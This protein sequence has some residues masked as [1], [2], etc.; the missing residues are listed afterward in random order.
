MLR[1][2]PHGCPVRR[3]LGKMC[4]KF[5]GRLVRVEKDAFDKLEF[6]SKG[7]L[8]FQGGNW[9]HAPFTL[10]DLAINWLNKV[11]IYSGEVPWTEIVHEMGHVFACKE[12]PSEHPSEFEFFGWEVVI[13]KKFDLDKWIENNRDYV[14]T[15]DNDMGM[16]SRPALDGILAERVRAAEDNGLLTKSGNPRSIR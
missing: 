5:G 9:D 13:A 15:G 8:V 7:G 11:V 3:E 4:H 16:L 2:L 10:R 12:P 14:V 6:S 1:S